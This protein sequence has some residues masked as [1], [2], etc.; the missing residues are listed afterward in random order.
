ADGGPGRPVELADLCR[1]AGEPGGARMRFE[2]F[3]DAWG[4]PHVRAG[5]E[6]DLAYGQGYVTARDRGWQLES[7][8]WRAEG[9]LAAR[10]GPGGLA[11]DRFAVRVRLVDT[12][13]R[14]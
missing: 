11:W 5:T 9:R 7:D 10:I 4:V 3:R 1:H 14:V 8:R 13:R 12:A 2:T 6:P